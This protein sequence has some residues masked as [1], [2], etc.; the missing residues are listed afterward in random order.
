MR[1]TRILFVLTCLC[2]FIAS[3][4]PPPDTKPETPQIMDF[5]ERTIPAPS[6][7]DDNLVVANTMFIYPSDSIDPEFE[8]W[9]FPSPD[10]DLSFTIE[11]AKHQA[12]ALH[13]PGGGIAFGHGI[14]AGLYRVRSAYFKFLFIHSSDPVSEAR[15][16]FGDE[17][18]W[19]EIKSGRVNNLGIFIWSVKGKDGIHSNGTI[20][21]KPYADVRDELKQRSDFE[22]WKSY[23]MF[24]PVSSAG[25]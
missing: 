25:N 17:S 14:P 11:N 2:L 22:P 5:R 15:G 3:C 21:I 18:A 19:F 1:V 9:R 4:A 16:Q 13:V 10:D 23:P 24:E 20:E 12:Y 6:S 7:P 8:M